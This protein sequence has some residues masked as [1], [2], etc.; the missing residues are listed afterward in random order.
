MRSS[1][2]LRP[3]PLAALSLCCALAGCSD[4]SSSV[5]NDAV[6]ITQPPPAA[7]V[8][9]W[10]L[11]DTIQIRLVNEAGEGKGGVSVSWSVAQG[12]G[13]VTPLA[14]TTG[15][16]GS[17]SAL[18][19]LGPVPGVNQ[20]RVDGGGL[21]ASLLTIGRA[22]QAERVD[23][24][25]A[26][27]CGLV[28]GA[29]WCWGNDSWVHSPPASDRPDPFG[30]AP[31]TSP[32]LVDDSHGFIDLA[33]SDN[34]V[35]ALDLH[36]SAWCADAEH[37][38]LAMVPGLPAV[39][40]L[41]RAPG[42]NGRYCGLAVSDSTAWC[43]ADASSPEAV[44]GSSGLL[45]MRVG[46][47]DGGV[48]ACGLRTDGGAVCW[49]AGPLGDGTT[50]ASATP[51][52]VSGDLQFTDLA[53]GDGFAC[54]LTSEGDVFCWGKDWQNGL[55]GPPDVLVPTLALSDADQIAASE[56]FVV[57]LK[58]GRVIA[59][60]GAGFDTEPVP[61][62]T[63]ISGL[64]GRAAASFALNSNSCLQLDDGQVY[65]WDEMWDQSSSLRYGVY[66]AV[67]PVPE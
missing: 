37:P 62:L 24:G 34:S 11:H 28:A 40:F 65:C 44:A 17:A 54:G 58:D 41:T 5:G 30:Y 14:A 52:A 60:Q 56:N 39:R 22:F 15:A 8:P 29:L 32:G 20:V 16:D 45:F 38:G 67:Q 26:L 2:I 50:A 13:T 42:G 12:G 23:A 49:G 9:G 10:P 25:Y 19:T 61:G 47:D 48:F 18:W 55:A 6:E 7:A 43:W 53:A 51:V 57:A 46:F 31:A 36:A 3:A 27:G 66:T 21:S 64:D 35:C 33:V 4:P 1:A 59:W 63:D